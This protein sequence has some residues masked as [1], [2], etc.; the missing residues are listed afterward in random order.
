MLHDSLKDEPSFR[1]LVLVALVV[2]NIF[3]F[4]IYIC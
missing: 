2:F 4:C 1:S 3:Q